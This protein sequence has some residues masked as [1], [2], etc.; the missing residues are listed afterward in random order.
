MTWFY[1]TAWSA[2]AGFD[3]NRLFSSLTGKVAFTFSDHVSFLFMETIN[4]N[5]RLPNFQSADWYFV[6]IA[7]W[8]W[9]GSPPHQRITV[10][11]EKVSQHHEQRRGGTLSQSC[12]WSTSGYKWAPCW[13]VIQKQR[14]ED[15]PIPIITLKM[16]TQD[17]WN[18][19]VSK[20]Y[21]FW[22]DEHWLYWLLQT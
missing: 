19:Q 4:R 9:H 3:C 6:T 5:Y 8:M 14:W 16:A 12:I 7:K 13:P 2:I 15:G 20:A 10:D 21:W 17:D 11:Q 1:C 22:Q 18:C